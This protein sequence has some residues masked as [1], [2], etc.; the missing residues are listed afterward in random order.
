MRT[1]VTGLALVSAACGGDDGGM[2]AGDE[3][4]PCYP[5]DTC[6]AGLA[7][8]AE[9]VCVA[10]AA[11]GAVA[12]DAAVA[13]GVVCSGDFTIVNSADLEALANCKEVTGDISLGDSDWLTE[14][15]LPA[16]ESIGGTLSIVINAGLT[17]IRL[18]ALKSSGGMGITT[19]IERV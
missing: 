19:I 15:S 1:L 6:N 13:I 3:G 9:S 4:A 11:D 10:M 7:C 5:N 2:G 18:P 16:L 12:G 17:S 14:L 8:T